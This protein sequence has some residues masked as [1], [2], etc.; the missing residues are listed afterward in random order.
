MSVVSH[1]QPQ[2]FLMAGVK[3]QGQTV[4]DSATIDVKKVLC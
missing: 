2:P 3:S 1:F 4:Q